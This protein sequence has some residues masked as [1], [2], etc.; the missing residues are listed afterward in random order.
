YLRAIEPP[1]EVAAVSRTAD[2]VRALQSKAFDAILLDLTL[3][4]AGGIDAV[5]ALRSAANHTP[6][7]VLSGQQDESLASMALQSGAQD[8]LIKGHIDGVILRRS[9]RYA[10]E[11]QQLLDRVAASEAR[12]QEENALLRRLTETAGRAFSTLD[13]QA[14]VDLF[15]SEATQLFHAAV[16]VHVLAAREHPDE[17]AAR[18]FLSR[19]AIQSESRRRLALPVAG[20]NGRNE[21]LLDINLPSKARFE[22]NDVFA[23]ELLRSYMEIAIQNGALFREVQQQR[24]SVL[25]LNR[26]KDDLI[27]VLAH[28]LKGPLTSIIGFA[29]VLEQHMLDGDEADKAL[30]TIRRAA[31]RLTALTNDTLALSKAEQGELNISKDPVNVADIVRDVAQTFAPDRK[32]TVAETGKE[33][34]VLGDPNRLRQVIENVIGNAVKYS[35]REEPVTVSI[36]GENRRIRIAVTDRGIGVPE[37]EAA[38]LFERFRRASNAKSSPVKGSGLGLYLA[39]TLVERH[40]GSIEV[41]SELG[42]GSTFTVVLPRAGGGAVRARNVLLLSADDTLA[43]FVLHELHSSGFA[44]C[45]DRTIGAALQRLDVESFELILIDRTS[46]TGDLS[47]LRDRAA[48]NRPRS[49]LVKIGGSPENDAPWSATLSNPF[50]TADLHDALERALRL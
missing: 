22:E 50:L 15:A 36:D 28:D 10:I 26:I 19:S 12:L 34:V 42:I 44:A 23:L 37:D 7:V 48:S 18:A 40:G 41:A 20:T 25:Q 46:V 39:K 43:P 32:I 33:P 21:W 45:R 31:L 4:D 2:A 49:L 38:F 27:A 30:A 17:F 11:R 16:T 8:Y 3:P 35:P 5:S 6:I 14:I 9:L 13:P 1:V 29:E 47:A 24:A